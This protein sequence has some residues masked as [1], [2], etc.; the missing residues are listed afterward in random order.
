MAAN[1]VTPAEYRQ[2][3]TSRAPRGKK[4]Y[5]LGRLKSGEM[6]K[7]EKSYSDHLALRQLA[8][9]IIWFKFE[10]IRLV[11]AERTTYAPDF[12]VMLA[13]GELQ[14]HET[15]G[16]RAIFMDDARVK[17]RVAAEQFP[18]R[19]VVAYPKDRKLTEWEFEWF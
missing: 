5:A 9:E 13:D 15:K 12:L 3:L 18:F 7:T 4:I 8:G 10:A 1:S 17:L 16:S 6:N 14:A 19:F 11:L 2:L